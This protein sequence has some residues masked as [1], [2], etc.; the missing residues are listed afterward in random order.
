MGSQGFSSMLTSVSSVLAAPVLPQGCLC[1][2]VPAAGAQSECRSPG[3]LLAA[4]DSHLAITYTA[5]APALYS[6]VHWT[7]VHLSHVTA[8]W[9]VTP[10]SRESILG[11]RRAT[12][13][14][15]HA[16]PLARPSTGLATYFMGSLFL[17]A[18]LV[19]I[20]PHHNA[21]S[22]GARGWRPARWL[23]CCLPL[24]MQSCPY[25]APSQQPPDEVTRLSLLRCGCKSCHEYSATIKALPWAV[26]VQE[27]RQGGPRAKGQK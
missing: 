24:G 18:R 15:L 7:D 5:P 23:P 27:D 2:A 3:L 16:P 13:E 6:G 26:R 12:F 1:P 9:R 11:M 4:L 21:R 8:L 20:G 14:D 22:R 25:L 10:L 17:L 19:S